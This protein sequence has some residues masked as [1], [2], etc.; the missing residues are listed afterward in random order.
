[1]PEIDESLPI[2]KDEEE[3]FVQQNPADSVKKIK[4]G[5]YATKDADMGGIYGATPPLLQRQVQ[6]PAQ[7]SAPA[8]NRKIFQNL[9]SSHVVRIKQEDQQ[10]SDSR[11]SLSVSIPKRY[12][13]TYQER[14]TD[15]GLEIDLATP[16]QETF[17]RPDPDANNTKSE[18]DIDMSEPALVG[19]SSDT[20]SSTASG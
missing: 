15:N 6:A 14:Q 18:E 11:A 12:R 7:A 3:L 16:V 5:S 4:R 20:I 1:M 9:L 8:G 13:L 19:A 10:E 2:R 17:I